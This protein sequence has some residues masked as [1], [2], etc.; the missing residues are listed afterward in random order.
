MAEQ[1]SIKKAADFTPTA[2]AKSSSLVFKGLIPFILLGFLVWA[3]WA[4]FNKP[5]QNITAQKGANVAIYNQPKRFFIPFIEGGIEQR[6]N[7][8]LA[9]YIR[10]GL[11]V[12]F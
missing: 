9:T 11:R 3:V 8:D 1:F 2:V 10:A 6:S 12:E 7:S 5:S 4:A